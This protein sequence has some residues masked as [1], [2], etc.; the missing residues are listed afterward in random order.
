MFL[1][2]RFLK[3]KVTKQDV[4]ECLNMEMLI[5]TSLSSL[6]QENR[7]LIISYLTLFIGWINKKWDWFL[8]NIKYILLMLMIDSLVFRINFKKLMSYFWRLIKIKLL[9]ITI[10]NLLMFNI[11]IINWLI[12]IVKENKLWILIIYMLIRRLLKIRFI[13]IIN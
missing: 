12:K 1:L 4:W 13:T 7:K 10:L 11:K 6:T 2:V 5:S 3:S 9:F 8:L